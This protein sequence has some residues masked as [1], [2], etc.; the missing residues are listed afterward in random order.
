MRAERH[1]LQDVAFALAPILPPILVDLRSHV[2]YYLTGQFWDD[3][4]AFVEGVD[5]NLQ[6]GI[7][8]MSHC[9]VLF[10][11]VLIRHSIEVQGRLLFIGL[12]A[13]VLI[14]AALKA[15]RFVVRNLQDRHIGDGDF[16]GTWTNHLVRFV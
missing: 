14:C 8:D 9:S 11:Q 7:V 16:C 6:T 12:P 15:H 3:I 1:I 10:D 5:H 13:V 2:P 4:E